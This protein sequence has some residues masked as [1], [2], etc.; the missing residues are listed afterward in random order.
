MYEVD[1]VT[2]NG[3]SIEEQIIEEDSLATK[4]ADLVK[5]GYTF[6]GYDFDFTHSIFLL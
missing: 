2:N 1:F 4:P 3:I 5:P 6:N